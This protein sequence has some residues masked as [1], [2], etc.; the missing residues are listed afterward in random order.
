MQYDAELDAIES[1]F[2]ALKKALFQHKS[3]VQLQQ[4]AGVSL[5][6]AGTSLLKAVAHCELR[7]TRLQDIGT[8][9]GVEAPTISRKVQQL[10]EEGLLEKLADPQDKRASNLELT[11]LGREQLHKLHIAQ[12]E[13]LR[14][15]FSQWTPEDR[16]QFAD[17]LHR[18]SNDLTNINERS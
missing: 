5:D 14:Q 10:V 12:R 15:L 9:L 3:W 11:Q 16:Q 13:R 18:F 4:E 7:P 17:L 1:A 8:S 6:K 2:A